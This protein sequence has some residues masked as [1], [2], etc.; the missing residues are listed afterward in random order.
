MKKLISV[1]T[2]LVL[3]AG[4]QVGLFPQSALADPTWTQTSY[5]D[6][7]NDSVKNDVLVID[8]GAG[9]GDVHLDYNV[10]GLLRNWP[11][12]DEIPVSGSQAPA[13]SIPTMPLMK[14][15]ALQYHGS[16]LQAPRESS[17][18]RCTT[19]RGRFVT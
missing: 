13:I 15:K 6:F 1:A 7:F 2:T 18:R 14:R 9:E 19:G 16:H 11:D 3:V 12:P 4:L 5:D 8:I 10:S 17:V